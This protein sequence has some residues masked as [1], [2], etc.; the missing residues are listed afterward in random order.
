M[1]GS[2]MPLRGS[3]FALSIDSVRCVKFPLCPYCDT[4]TN[5]DPQTPALAFEIGLVCFPEECPC[6]S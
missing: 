5:I 4:D 6:A 1:E 2:D 3:C